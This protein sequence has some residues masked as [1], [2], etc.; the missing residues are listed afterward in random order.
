MHL[1]SSV[2]CYSKSSILG[3]VWAEIVEMW[4]FHNHLVAEYFSFFTLA[5]FPKLFYCR[6][7]SKRFPPKIFLSWT[8]QIPLGT[9]AYGSTKEA[10]IEGKVYLYNDGITPIFIPI[11]VDI[12][13]V[14]YM[15]RIAVVVTWHLWSFPSTRW[16][17]QSTVTLNRAHQ[18][19]QRKLSFNDSRR[20][21][22]RT[23]I[24]CCE[25]TWTRSG[26]NSILLWAYTSTSSKI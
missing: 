23:A 8:C 15:Y 9:K 5:G 13:T 16:S 14:K 21:T 18:I 12:N 2:S 3:L 7:F 19:T 22:M 10:D 1:T 25:E 26:D 11:R 4:L 24:R 6:L 17:R 20:S